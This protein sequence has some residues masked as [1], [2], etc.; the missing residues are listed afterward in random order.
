MQLLTDTMFCLLLL[1]KTYSKP[2]GRRSVLFVK[3]VVYDRIKINKKEL[4]FLLG[5][6]LATVRF[7]VYIVSD[8]ILWAID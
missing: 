4:F 1:K 8:S 2:D 3:I 6:Y 5:K 7:F